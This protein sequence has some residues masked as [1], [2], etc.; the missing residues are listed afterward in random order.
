MARILFTCFGS[1]GDLFPYLA[2]A[3][4]LKARGHHVAIGTTSL[5]APQV[6]AESIAFVHLRCGFDR[7]VTPQLARQL[8]ERLFDPVQGGKIITQ[9]MMGTVAETFADTR[10]AIDNVDVVVSNPLAYATPIACRERGIPWL[11]TVLAPMF[12]MSTFDP[13][14]MT[15]APWLSRLHRLSPGLYRGIFALIKRASLNWTKPL[16]ELC[17]QEGL[18][19]PDGHPLFEGQYSPH[20]TL[21]MFPAGFATPQPDWPPNTQLTGFPYF[22]SDASEEPVMRE[23]ESF[24]ASGDAPMVFALGSSAVNIAGDFF[25]VSANVA[26]QLGQR[27]V[28]VYGQHA[29]QIK[30]IPPGPDI[31]ALPYVSYDKLFKRA[32]IVVHQGG[33]GTLAQAMRAQ[34]PML[35]VPFGFDQP[36][37]GQRIERLGLGKSLS[38]ANYRIDTALPV[39]RELLDSPKYRKNAETTGRGMAEEDGLNHAA[40]RIEV[41]VTLAAQEGS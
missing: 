38:R 34:R 35:V 41:L 33:I 22:S 13:P 24:L 31:L 4:V 29:D 1:L 2:V 37:N 32:S 11:S 27:A 8:L 5:Y 10:A 14:I 16:Y 15:P 9:E 3:K 12:L 28:L 17:R 20:G 7:F 19:P 39:L 26:R 30:G 21:A 36:D 40:D 25:A 6:E 23:L 18:A